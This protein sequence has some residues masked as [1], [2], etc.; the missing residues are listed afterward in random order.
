MVT[1]YDL[2]M[3]IFAVCLGFILFILTRLGWLLWK[4]YQKKSKN[5]L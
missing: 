5:S 2:E 4:D 3:L 1:K